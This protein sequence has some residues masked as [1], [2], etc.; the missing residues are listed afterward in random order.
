MSRAVLVFQRERWSLLARI[1]Q[2][3]ALLPN[4]NTNTNREASTEKRELHASS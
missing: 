1:N 4:L 3:H 2:R